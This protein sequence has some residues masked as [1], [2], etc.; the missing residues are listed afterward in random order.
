MISAEKIN[1]HL[2]ENPIWILSATISFICLFLIIEDIFLLYELNM[3]L[4]FMNCEVYLSLR[5]AVATE[6]RYI[7][8]AIIL[9]AT[10]PKKETQV[11]LISI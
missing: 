10:N 5:E 7:K 4:H 11:I 3:E 6:Q 1:H 2:Q 8:D 9:N